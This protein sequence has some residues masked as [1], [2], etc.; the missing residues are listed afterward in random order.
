[1]IRVAAG[2]LPSLGIPADRPIYSSWKAN[3]QLYR[4]LANPETI[5]DMWT[6][7]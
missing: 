2:E 5:G 6:G 4:F 3:P 1:M 7:L